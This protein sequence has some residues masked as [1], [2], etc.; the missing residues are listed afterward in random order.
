[1]L[2][3]NQGY[4]LLQPEIIN[5][6]MADAASISAE[7][8]MTTDIQG[9][10]ENKITLQDQKETKRIKIKNSSLQRF[11][12]GIFITSELTSVKGQSFRK[13]GFNGGFL[14]GYNINKK[15]QAEVGLVLSRKYY[16]SDGKYVAPDILRQD[17]L[18]IG[19]VNVYSQVA[20]IPVT[21]R[22][23]IK[24]TGNDKLFVAAG[25]VTNIIAEER[26]NYGYTKNG[27]SKKG[28]KKY[29]E[30]TNNLV[31]NVHLS[32]GYEHNL[33]TIGDIRI[34]PYYRLP[35]NGIGAGNLPVTSAGINIGIIKH[36][37]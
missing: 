22:Y 12:G 3:N 4:Q 32:I 7:H 21:L 35:L 1:L 24:N 27:H 30:S 9:K 26:Y 6:S 19:G 18:P 16:Y 11:Y 34:E 28:F 10:K 33:G 29:D 5:G 8:I 31:S 14:A 23:N 37:K 17:D 25:T 36:F 2:Q 13:P 20:E 15:F